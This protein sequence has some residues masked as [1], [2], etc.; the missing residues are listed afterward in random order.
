LNTAL[1]RNTAPVRWTPVW[2]LCLTQLISWGT[3]YYAFSIFLHPTRAGQG[4][5]QEQMVGAYSL[6]LLITGLCAYPV[7]RLIHRFDGRAVMSIGSITA[8]AAFGLLS[9]CDSLLM[10]YVA[11][12]LAGVAMGCT[13]YEA[14]FSVLAAVYSSE[15]K[16][17]VTTVTLAGGFASTIFWPFTERLVAWLGWREAAAVYAG[18]HLVI[19]LPLHYFGLPK[20]SSSGRNSTS[21][22]IT[23]LS[24]LIRVRAVWLLAGSYTLNAVVFSAISVH[25]VPLFQSRGI[26]AQQAAWI[27]ACAGPMQ[28]LGR[29]VEFKFGHRWTGTQTGVVAL[30]LVVPALFG[31][32]VWPLPVAIVAV[33]VGLYGVSNGVMTIVRGVSVVEVFGRESFAAVNGALMAPALVARALGPML[34]SVIMERTGRYEPVFFVLGCLATVSLGLFSAGMRKPAALHSPPSGW[35]A[36]AVKTS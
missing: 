6:S 24:G 18:L 11:W 22:R 31:F 15:Y 19:C 1:D 20:A 27:A 35:Q 3:L 5:T 9:A 10:F 14:A 36:D 34:A 32:A 26:A 28:V 2:V 25:L 8:A 7:G 17:V 29:L 16:R 33:A 30:A 23:T 12:A 4:W 21:A 13:L